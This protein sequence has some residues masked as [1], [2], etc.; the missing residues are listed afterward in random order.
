MRPKSAAL[1]TLLTTSNPWGQS[2]LDSFAQYLGESTQETMCWL[3]PMG[4]DRIVDNGAFGS[5]VLIQPVIKRAI[6][7]K[8]AIVEILIF[9]SKKNHQSCPALVTGDFQADITRPR[10]PLSRGFGHTP[11]LPG[12]KPRS[13]V[14]TDT[15]PVI[16]GLKSPSPPQRTNLPIHIRDGR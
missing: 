10:R 14:M 2:L 15:P 16:S 7:A 11:S 13:D 12:P 3:G 9:F 4:F 1:T 8:S 5:V 6:T